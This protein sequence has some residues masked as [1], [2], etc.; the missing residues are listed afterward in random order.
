MI[1]EGK[2]GSRVDFVA[3]LPNFCLT[4]LRV[5]VRR[6]RVS[7]PEVGQG[8]SPGP[9]LG[10]FLRPGGLVRAARGRKGEGRRLVRPERGVVRLSALQPQL[11]RRV[12]PRVGVGRQQQQ[13]PGEAV[14]TGPGE[15]EGARPPPG[16]ALPP[17]SSRGRVKLG[18]SRNARVWRFDG[19]CGA[20]FPVRNGGFWG[21]RA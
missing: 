10:G 7:T 21:T 6:S 14:D 8:S 19:K 11:G 2:A 9:P 18:M 12:G 15:G 13:G 4:A 3:R 16:P 20:L 17:E 1:R 5:S